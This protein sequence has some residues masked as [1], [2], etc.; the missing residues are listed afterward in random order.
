MSGERELFQ[1]ST[2][3]ELFSSLEIMSN[4]AFAEK[5]ADRILFSHCGNP[6]CK[7]VREQEHFTQTSKLPTNYYSFKLGKTF[8]VRDNDDMKMFCRYIFS[9][10]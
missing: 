5:V 9:L 10:P 6:L 2:E 8:D 1:K 4:V 3:K 7:T